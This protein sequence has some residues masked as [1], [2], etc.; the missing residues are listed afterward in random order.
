MTDEEI[1]KGLCNL[2]TIDLTDEASY[3]SCGRLIP[4]RGMEI[5]QATLD[6][7]NRLKKEKQELREAYDFERKLVDVERKDTAKEILDDL[8]KACTQGYL[9]IGLW[10][11]QEY[12]KYGVEV[13]DE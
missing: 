2:S 9:G 1:E 7:I 12:I 3:D 10:T 4:P 8:K 5:I 6:Y 11:R 13:D